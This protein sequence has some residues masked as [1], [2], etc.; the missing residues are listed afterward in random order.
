M[1]TNNTDFSLRSSYI[2][3]DVLVMLE[4]DVVLCMSTASAVD[5]PNEDSFGEGSSIIF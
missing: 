5:D 2:S 3:P 1:K 4:E